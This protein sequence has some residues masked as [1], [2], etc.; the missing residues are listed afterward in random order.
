MDFML[1]EEMHQMTPRDH[2]IMVIKGQTMVDNA[3]DK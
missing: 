3:K 2:Q 1:E